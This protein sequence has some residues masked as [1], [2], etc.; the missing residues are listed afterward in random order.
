MTVLEV[1]D[2]P[3]ALATLGLGTSRRTTLREDD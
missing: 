1:T 2:L 3:G